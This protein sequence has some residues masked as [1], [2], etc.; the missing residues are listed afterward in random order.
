MPYLC[1]KGLL[2]CHLN[3]VD[4]VVFLFLKLIV[5]IFVNVTCSAL[6]PNMYIKPKVK[7]VVV[8]FD[9]L[10][11]SKVRQPNKKP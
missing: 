7:F 8:K 9:S 4:F 5:W 3:N 11:S 2:E 1:C 10:L 6:A